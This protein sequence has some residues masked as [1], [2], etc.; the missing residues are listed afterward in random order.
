M[1]WLARYSLIATRLAGSLAITAMALLLPGCGTNDPNAEVK[2]PDPRAGTN[3]SAGARSKPME[4]ESKPGTRGGL[5]FPVGVNRYSA[6]AVFTK[7]GTVLLHMLDKEGLKTLEVEEQSI[8][9]YARPLSAFES[10]EFTLKAKPQPGNSPGKTTLFE[11]SLPAGMAG[12]MVDVSIP[13]LRVNGENF[14]LGI[15]SK[16]ESTLPK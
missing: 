16:G 11:G 3:H 7:D 14:R 4:Q 1:G 6:E 15:Q 5:I 10:S 12:K 13:M 8:K 9:A 2:L